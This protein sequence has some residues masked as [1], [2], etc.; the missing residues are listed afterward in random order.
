[1]EVRQDELQ[2]CPGSLP[3]LVRVGQTRKNCKW[4]MRETSDKSGTGMGGIGKLADFEC[5]N[6]NMWVIGAGKI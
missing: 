1:M 3:R 5:R 6:S 4:W 2:D